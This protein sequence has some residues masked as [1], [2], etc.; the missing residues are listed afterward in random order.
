VVVVDLVVDQDLVP[1]L[2]EGNNNVLELTEGLPMTEDDSSPCGYFK[3]RRSSQL[4]T[5]NDWLFQM[6]GKHFSD[7]EYFDY[8]LVNGSRRYSSLFYITNCRRCKECTAIRIPVAEFQMSKSQ[9]AVLRKNEDITVKIIK[10]NIV[11]TDEKALLYRE[12]DNFHNQNEPNYK[13]LTLEEAKQRLQEMTGG[14][15]GVW[16]MEYYLGERLIAV[17]IVD[18]TE[19]SEGKINAVSSNY[20]FY[21]VSPEIRKRSLGVFSVLKEIELCQALEINFYYLGLYLPSCR[22]MNYKINYKPYELYVDG[23]WVRYDSDKNDV[24]ERV[25]DYDE[26]KLDYIEFPKPGELYPDYPEICM[27]T[28]DI[29]IDYLYSAYLQGI[30]PWFSEEDDQP[31]LWQ[32]PDPR[33]VIEVEKLHVPKSIDKFLKHTPYTYTM[34]TCFERVMEECGKMKR[35]DQ[36]GTWIGPKMLKAYSEFH[37]RGYAHS[38]E[39]WHKGELVGG[40]YGVLI[41]SVFCGESMFTKM[42]DSSKSAFVLFARAFAE[43]GGKLIDCQVYTDNM[44]RY[45]AVE[46]PRKDFLELECKCFSM[47]LTKK[48]TL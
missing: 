3:G 42:T 17:G 33:F 29:S 18:Y 25:K 11:Q 24:Q 15:S 1:A 8:L 7:K 5:K 43:A 36:D 19:N 28:N 26:S 31:V 14:Y 4:I 35:K 32:S 38:V 21:D 37:K 13:K 46:M 47:E 2:A 45:G 30:F 48:I 12:Y 20:F 39:V 44:A 6:Y 41:G 22:K 10:E 16:N 27:V 34:D 23:Q 9:K 40:F